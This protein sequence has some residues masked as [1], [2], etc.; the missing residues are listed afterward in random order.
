MNGLSLAAVVSAL[1]LAANSCAAAD[2][3][4][5]R[6]I[7]QE[8]CLV[9]WAQ[10]H[11]P[12][13]CERI[14]EGF[15]VL[16]DRKGGA[17]FLLIPTR[18]MSG[19][20]SPEVLEPGAPNYFEAAWQARDQLA[21]KI[22]HDVPRGAVGLALNPKHSRSQD[23]LHIHIEC[24]RADVAASLQAASAHLTSAWSAVSI[25]G[26][27]YDA[28]R[29]MGEELGANPFHLLAD[30][31]PQAKAAL[32]DY[33]IIV[34]GMQFMEGAGFVVLAGTGLAGELL[35]DSSCAAA[36]SAPTADNF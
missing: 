14:G 7:V 29:V 33:T 18:T 34:A 19:I 9:H 12:V 5:L 22:G 15:A 11:S 24:L 32:E 25:A 28:L 6:R 36:H 16:A 30:R 2:R 23:Q 20:E 26:W 1:G 31:A 4:A 13:P 10:Q 21:A 3:D 27:H 17:H 35:L 8:E